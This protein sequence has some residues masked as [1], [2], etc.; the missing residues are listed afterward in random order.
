MRSRV[1]GTSRRCRNFHL[2]ENRIPY[3]LARKVCLEKCYKIRH[4][5]SPLFGPDFVD[6]CIPCDQPGDRQVKAKPGRKPR[7][8]PIAIKRHVDEEY[9]VDYHDVSRYE[10]PRSKRR[11]IAPC[12]SVVTTPPEIPFDMNIDHLRID[13][14]CD[15]LCAARELMRLSKCQPDGVAHD[16]WPTPNDS[17]MGGIIIYKGQ[18]YHWDGADQLVPEFKPQT[19]QHRPSLPSVKELV[20]F[21]SS[22]T[23]NRFPITP[24]PH[25]S[26]FHSGLPYD[27][28]NN[29]AAQAALISPPMSL[30]ESFNG[31]GRE[32]HFSIPAADGCRSPVQESYSGSLF[33]S[34]QPENRFED[35]F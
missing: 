10:R 2:I 12:A 27:W 31:L 1:L 13:E 3:E 20:D 24:S 14:I 35:G 5:L 25:Q 6:D 8:L 32:R 34:P 22:T 16:D 7:S 33:P 18:R 26:P 17:R 30:R 23:Y 4:Y 19:P 29:A 11:N 21:P 28:Q 15:A 9:D